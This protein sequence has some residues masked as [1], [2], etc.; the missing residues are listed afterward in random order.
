M[1]NDS[2]EIHP[3]RQLPVASRYPICTHVRVLKPK[4]SALSW[5]MKI[6]TPGDK[7]SI[8]KALLADTLRAP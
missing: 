3:R 2:L 7:R 6:G 1:L 5:H 8:C 4:S